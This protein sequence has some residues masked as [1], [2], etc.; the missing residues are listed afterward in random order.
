MKLFNL[1]KKETANSKK[2]SV[3]TLEKK[4]LEKVIGG[5]DSTRLKEEIKK[6]TK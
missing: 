5:G 6:V 1:F 2:V 4:Q 3:Q